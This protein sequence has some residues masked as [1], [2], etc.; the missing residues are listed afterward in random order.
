MDW[1][2]LT[3]AS[4]STL[5]TLA[6][7]SRGSRGCRSSSVSRRDR[8]AWPISTRLL[9]PACNRR[10]SVMTPA[11]DVMVDHHLNDIPRPA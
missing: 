10:P 2:S 6:M 1:L 8:P 9:L 11:P 7:V 3:C 4:S 5:S